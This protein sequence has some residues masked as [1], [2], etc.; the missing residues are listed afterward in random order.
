MSVHSFRSS[1]LGE[2][3]AEAKVV[4]PVVGRVVVAISHATVPGVVVPAATAIHAVRP[5]LRLTP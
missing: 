5:T 2:G 1:K 4:V 3:K